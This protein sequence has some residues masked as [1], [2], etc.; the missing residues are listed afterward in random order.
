MIKSRGMRWEGYVACMR[1]KRSSYRILV[2][3]SEG[4]RPL[5]TP[6][7]RWEDNI[8]ADH[9]DRMEWYGLDRSGSGL[10]PVEGS[11]E[12]GN[13]ASGSIKCWENLE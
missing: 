13:E 7:H 2:G 5:R 4:K 1:K 10:G 6:R 11:C 3:M 9:K 12:H 8:T